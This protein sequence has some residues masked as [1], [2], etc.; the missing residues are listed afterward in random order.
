MKQTL[1]L[2]LL[3]ATSALA[4]LV[5]I[6]VDIPNGYRG[7]AVESKPISLLAS[8]TSKAMSVKATFTSPPSS[9]TVAIQPRLV[10]TGLNVVVRFDS[11]V[12]LPVDPFWYELRIDGTVRF[13]G[14][15]R[16]TK[17]GIVIAGA[18]GSLL[19]S[20]STQS[21]VLTTKMSSL[22]ASHTTLANRVASLS[23]TV[24]S[25]TG[26]NGGVTSYTA[27]T[28]RPTIPTQAN[29]VG[30]V[31][32]ETYNTNRTN[33]QSA[34][35]SAQ[36]TANTALSVAN[37]ATTSAFNSA[38]AIA[39][40]LEV[41]TFNSYT[42]NVASTLG[43]KVNVSD[44]N[45]FT[46]A[47]AA[48]ISSKLAT[49]SFINYTSVTADVIASRLAITDFVSFTTTN[50]S[51][52]L[53]KLN[54]SEFASYT[55]ATGNVLTGKVDNTIFNNFTAV[56]NTT[57]ASKLNTSDFASYSAATSAL[58][59]D[60]LTTSSFNSYTSSVASGLSN[61]LDIA[62]YTTYTANVAGVINGKEPTIGAGLTSQYWRGDKSWQSLN[63]DVVPDG[64]TNKAFTSIERSK[65]AG[66]SAGATANSTDAFLL[67]RANHTG[68][69]P[70]ITITEDATHRFV[71]DSQT[72]NW[73]AKQDALG[74]T[75]Y[76]ST[77]PSGYQTQS[78]VQQL[79]D[80]RYRQL[81]TPI[82]YTLDV[83]DKPTIPASASE[84]GAVSL[85]T[86]S[87]NR[88]TD[89]AATTT[90]QNTANTALSTANSATLSASNNATAIAANTSAIAGKLDT[91]VF[92]SYTST[93]A[94]GL[95]GKVNTTDFN[96]FTVAN[97]SALASKVDVSNFNSYTTATASAIGAKL[98]TSD[99]V[100]YSSTNATYLGNKLETSLFSSYTVTTAGVL[101]SKLDNSTFTSFTA[102]N[103]TNLGNK[104]DVSTFNSYSS[105][106]ASLIADR[107]TSS[108]YNSYTTS[109]ASAL[110]SKVET[111]VYNSYTTTA[112]SAIDG[113]QPLNSN[114]TT[115]GG[116]APSNDDFLQRKAGAWTFR[117]LTQVKN[118]LNLVGTNTGDQ[119]ITLTGD[120]TGSGTGSF[121]TTLATVNSNVGTF[122][123][124]TINAKGLATGGSNIAYLTGNQS[125]SFAPT[126]DVTGS[127]SGATSLAP[128]LTIGN[129]VVSN[130]K[131]A[132]VATATI[133]GRTTAGAGNVED[134]SASQ[135]RGVMGLGDLA[136]QNANSL[137]TTA[138]T[139][140]SNVTMSGNLSVVSG[141][142]VVGN[143]TPTST[144]APW[145]LNM[146]GTYSTSPTSGLK[147]VVYDDGTAKSGF[148]VSV[149]QFNYVI[150]PGLSHVFSIGGT[151]VATVSSAGLNISASNPRIDFGGTRMLHATGTQSVFVGR[152]AG[153]TTTTG[154]FNSAL[155]ES[156]GTALTSGQRNTFA[157]TNSGIGVTGGNDN[158][159]IGTNA[160]FNLTTSSGNTFVGKD[161]GFKTGFTTTS[162]NN[163]F[164]G[165][166]AGMNISGTTM[167]NVVLIG[168]DAGNGESN[169]SNTAVFG[170][171][172]T[173][174]LIKNYG[175]YTDSG[176]VEVTDATKGIILKSPNGTRWRVTVSNAGVLT[177]T[178]L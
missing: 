23:A 11:S 93:S 27:L 82:S 118:D 103:A 97:T 7:N 15:V 44:L 36:A 139:S 5:P 169:L 145:S 75:P 71:T 29:Q 8:D 152:S 55:S 150:G 76:N 85:S 68:L 14:E 32:I 155:G 134:L 2:F 104:L 33:D 122:N 66:I 37:S 171:S 3:T 174:L 159:L 46:T 116:L 26:V 110:S 107:V 127:A 42:G 1:I 168:Y 113:K 45:S 133:K 57:L 52:L 47:N 41:S 147:F 50:M 62:T 6:R 125:I 172:A 61:K 132:T 161:A 20:L 19:N 102:A 17:T 90:A 25:L 100:S 119:T 164:I 177:T 130:A 173:P 115:I 74:Y 94:T 4:Q 142:I 77:N 98:A 141:N 154:Q 91:S 65:L 114:L 153:N 22:S 148:G 79:G 158:T 58:I 63:Q 105:A 163:T 136:L 56:A 67:G 95:N 143:T 24:S 88:S 49:S 64:V 92:N 59:A 72:A 162:T 54:L 10:R 117:T 166:G 81:S 165:F 108:T 21:G 170:K 12:S 124:I 109:I 60:R 84:V 144:T 16:V 43:S 34:T 160:G 40:R 111:S 35:S 80:A 69:Q 112:A 135:A 123:N 120:V 146:G 73:N 175:G 149:G 78:D 18:D 87:S 101:S 140:M 39:S 129:N 51:A 38:T 167:N 106:T 13:Y 48:N 28:D 121:A 31:S 9:Q 157:G 30:A 53:G 70:A 89:Q 131:L 156:A 138:T 137:T 96:S 126:G 128:T 178:S 151:G 83:I 86:Y 176:D 99:F